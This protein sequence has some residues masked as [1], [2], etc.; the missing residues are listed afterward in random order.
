MAPMINVLPD[1]RTGTLRGKQGYFRVGQTEAGQWW[2]IDAKDRPFFAKMVH[3]VSADVEATHDP[4]ARLRT[5][6]FNA[7]GCGSQNLALDEGL[8][9][10][11]TVDFCAR[12]AGVNLGGVRLPD[13]FAPDWPTLAQKR[14]AEVC[15][16]HRENRELLGWITDDDPSWP[17]QP[18]TESPG[19]LQVCLSLDPDKSAYHA[20][21]EFVLA[22]YGGN[23]ETLAKAWGV[24]LA[25]KEAL[26]VMTREEHGIATAGHRRDDAQWSREFARRYFSTTVSA[27]RQADPNHLVCG[28]RWGAP[29]SAGLRREC[30]SSVDVSL[31]DYSEL[32][33]VT[34]GAVILGNFCWAQKSFYGAA[35][36]RRGLG[37][38]KVERMLRR[39]RLGLAEAVAHP[40]VVGYAWRRWHDRKGETP[41]FGTGLVR[42]DDSAAVE[43]TELLTIINDRVEE[44][45][46]LALVREEMI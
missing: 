34:A 36:A 15:A 5:W 9:F 26:R 43:H 3:R 4:A 41:P 13:V 31:V 42:A 14:A 29:V 1:F 18:E 28:P 8:P 44:L 20:A 38:T 16:A 39:G 10:L 40:S 46:A 35:H 23:L 21:W 12:N 37:P 45:R 2:L 30:A 11:A 25:N 19:L 27:I 33:E 22:L 7:L 6:G 32:G 24:T 17:S